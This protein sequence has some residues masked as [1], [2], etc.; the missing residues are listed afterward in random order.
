MQPTRGAPINPVPFPGIQNPVLTKEDVDDVSATFVADPF[1]V[2]EEG[3]FHMFFE[4]KGEGYHI[5][6]ATST[7]GLSWEYDEVVIPDS[8]IPLT[9]P[10]V[11]KENGEWLMVPAEAGMDTDVVRILK[12]NN[13]PYDWEVVE[14]DII[15]DH[16][17][18]ATTF[19]FDD[20][21]YIMHQGNDAKN[22]DIY[23]YYSENGGI[24]NENW[25]EH[26]ESP[27]IIQP[28]GD[29]EFRPSGRPIVTEDYVDH[30]QRLDYVS[31]DE[32]LHAFRI[33]E[34]TTSTF[35]HYELPNS[36]ILEGTGSGWNA[37]HMHHLDPI[38]SDVIG[39]DIYI[40]DGRQGGEWSIGIYTNSATTVGSEVQS[41]QV[42]IEDGGTIF[43]ADDDGWDTRDSMSVS[44]TFDKEFD[45]TP[46]VVATLDRDS[47][48]NGA[49]GLL[50]TVRGQS[51]NGF[52]M[53]VYNYGTHDYAENNDDVVIDWIASV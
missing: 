35:E 21:W 50:A 26:P 9:Y 16:N 7:D 38:P 36:P 1:C 41:G 51:T 44:V 12:A 40:V 10:Q 29:A 24:R 30:W 13:F 46:R 19:K 25:I 52:D 47:S 33:T 37:S 15:T 31:A 43:G 48:G 49:S 34:L 45:S 11:F 22:R 23:L 18:D 39:S 3:V 42:D 53:I 14:E 28:S 5:G 32:A 6:H 27:I 2:Y 8:Q 17:I 4:I 20:Q